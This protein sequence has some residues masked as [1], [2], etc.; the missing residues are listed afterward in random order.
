[1]RRKALIVFGGKFIQDTTLLV[2][3]ESCKFYGRYEKKHF[4]LLFYWDTLLDSQRVHD[5]HL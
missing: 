2:L 4:S 5:F 1:M 3:S